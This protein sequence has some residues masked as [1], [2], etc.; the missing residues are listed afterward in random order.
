LEKGSSLLSQKKR[1]RGRSD[2][3]LPPRREK[4]K[5]E[6]FSGSFLRRKGERPETSIS[7]KERGKMGHPYFLRKRMEVARN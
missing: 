4:E 7:Q 2:L 1:K 3:T 6:A 5:K